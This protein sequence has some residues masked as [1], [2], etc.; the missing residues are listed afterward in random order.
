MAGILNGKTVIVTGSTRGL[1]VYAFNPGLMLTEMLS[2]TQAIAGY[3]A[4]MAPLRTVMRLWGNPPEVPARK[5]VWLASAA[6]DGRTGLNVQQ[7][8]TAGSPA[9]RCHRWTCA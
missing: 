6:T 3:E 5:L 1:G 4:R 7:L 9:A 8:G 2:D